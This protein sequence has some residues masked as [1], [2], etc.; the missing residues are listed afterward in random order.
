M[1]ADYSTINPVLVIGGMNL[2]LLGIAESA[3]VPGDSRP[4][5]IHRSP[6]G[7]ARNIAARL[8][9]AGA[10]VALICP[11]SNDE[12]AKLLA[13]SCQAVGISLEYAVPTK[14][15]TPTYLAIHDDSGDM[16]AAINDMRA[17]DA[18][19]PQNLLMKVNDLSAFS[20]CVLD[21]N[22][23]EACLRYAADT[24]YLPL[25]ADP[26]SVAKGGKLLPILH[27]LRAIKP[28]LMEA[29]SLTGENTSRDCAQALLANGVHQ[30]FISL[31]KEGLYY[32]DSLDSGVCPIRHASQASQTGAG[33]AMTAGLTLGIIQDLPIRETAALGLRFADNFL[34]SQ[35]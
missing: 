13:E 33:D 15:P 18:L 28:N 32:A 35:L 6:G 4:G 22:L 17:M 21:A 2:D 11:L 34:Q 9:L 27:R 26:V 30:V 1:T 10:P 20:A 5:Y 29:R 7:V 14:E 16:V 31:G 19:T 25:I 24:I 8:A 3:F 23:S 12:M